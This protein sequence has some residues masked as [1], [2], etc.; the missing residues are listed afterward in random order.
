MSVKV[1]SLSVGQ[2][3]IEFL[4]NDEPDRARNEYGPSVLHWQTPAHAEIPQCG[5]REGT[6]TFIVTY[7]V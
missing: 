6:A 2:F 7:I 3:V 4:D 5:D 1:T